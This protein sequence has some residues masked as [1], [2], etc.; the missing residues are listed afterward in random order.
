VPIAIFSTRRGKVLAFYLSVVGLA[1]SVLGF[2]LQVLPSWNQP[3]GNII[4]MAMPAHAGLAWL[5][6]RLFKST[7]VTIKAIE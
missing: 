1:L 7:S 6:Y 4:A 3:N 2:I 5:M